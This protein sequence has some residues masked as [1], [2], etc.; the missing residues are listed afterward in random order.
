[1]NDNLPTFMVLQTQVEYE[2]EQPAGLVAAV[3]Q[4]L[5]FLGVCGGGTAFGR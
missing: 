5:S 3:E 4:R 2:G 1:M